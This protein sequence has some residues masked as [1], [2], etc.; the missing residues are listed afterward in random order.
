MTYIPNRNQTTAFGDVSVS[1]RTPIVQVRATYGEQDVDAFTAL[2]GTS[3]IVDGKYK[4]T[5]GT[6]PNA[7]A[8]FLSVRSVTYRPGQG[9]LAQITGRFDT[10]SAG[11]EI[12]CG[13]LSA[14]DG[15][16]FGYSGTT[17]GIVHRHDGLNEIREL[18]V[19][20]AAAGAETATVTIDG[21][22]HTVPLTAGTVQHNAN[23]LA[24]SL[25]AN[26]A[27]QYDVVSVDDT[28][29]FVS[30]V[31]EPKV[32]AFTFSSTGTA[33][34][35]WSTITTGVPPIVDVVPQT[36]W[37][38]NT[39]TGLDPSKMNVYKIQVQFLGGGGIKFFIEDSDTAE[40]VH[41]HTIRYANSFTVP[42]V[43][44]PSFRLGWLAVNAGVNTT[45][46]T[47]EG[48]SAAG[49]I[50]GD[51]TVTR[52]GRA[53][54]N[55]KTS[56]GTT[57]TNIL[58]LRNRR[59]FGARRN[60]TEVRPQIISISSDATKPVILQLIKNATL[61]GTPVFEYVDKVNSSVVVDTAGTT[62][63]GGTVIFSSGEGSFDLSAINETLAPGESLTV[64]AAVS[65]VPA[66]DMSATITWIEDF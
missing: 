19:T 27:V 64:G 17:F 13:F 6:D 58:T 49:F 24:A 21:T 15:Y 55:V 31:A 43:G 11:G 63:T 59:A 18:Q 66:A 62:I 46:I 12:S 3:T 34:A 22:G 32:G 30:L 16:A 9:S 10:P 40:F 38:V 57:I 51:L 14:T 47:V 23:E 4:C 33:T 53:Q 28:C 60:L 56:V 8:T 20:V 1:K 50:E 39:V 37:N 42:S 26:P 29:V 25:G 52:P 54:N 36:T 2:G 48:S 35:V 5:T 65:A 44:N 7:F 45:P 61:G 41:V